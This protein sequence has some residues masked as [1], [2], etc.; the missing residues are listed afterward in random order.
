MIT[1]YKK[2][3]N[4]IGFW[5]IAVTDNAELYITHAKKV[6]GEVTSRI[7]PVKPKNVGRANETTALEQAHLE[8]VS[9]AKK[10]RDKGYV[11]SVAEA[12]EFVSVAPVLATVLE[13][14]KLSEE[15]FYHA[16]LQPKLNGHRCLYRE[17][18]LW[19][20]GGKLIELPHIL[21]AIHAQ[22]L[23]ESELD[24][25][26]YIH[27]MP[28]QEI[29]SLIKRPREE[30]EQVEY[31]IYDRPAPTAFTP[32]YR[33]MKSVNYPLSLVPTCKVNTME[34]AQD[35][36]G[37]FVKAGYEGAML[38]IGTQGYEYGKRSRNLLKL[39]VYQDVEALVVGHEPAKPNGK[40][41]SVCWIC[42]NPFGEGTFKVLAQ[43]TWEE[44]DHQAVNADHY[45]GRTLTVKYFELSTARM[46]QQ[47]I[48]L[49]WKEEL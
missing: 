39:K 47:P 20:R 21:E 6:G 38:R 13:K 23:S 3:S 28:L 24:G 44:V 45:V 34:Q 8:M 7:T 1:L 19:S 41:A 32:R 12:E 26:L 49:Q 48:A 46:P 5:Q 43:G 35:L 4:S 40:L 30:S 22:G 11:D 31:H 14:V 17:G 2:L 27:G 15:D 16:Y 10:Q 9:R 25:E 42:Q 18:Q 37:A 36:A 33:T 29:G